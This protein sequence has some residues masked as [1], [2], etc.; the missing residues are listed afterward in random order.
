MRV[1]SVAFF[2]PSRLH[3]APLEKHDHRDAR[4]SCADFAAAPKFRCKVRNR[5]GATG[6]TAAQKALTVFFPLPTSSRRRLDTA[7]SGGHIIGAGVRSRRC[8]AAT[9]LITA[10]GHAVSNCLGSARASRA[11][12]GAAR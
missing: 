7:V 6:E 9:I 11:H 12:V 8:Y 5:A 4:A 1:R 3:P 2:R 10:W